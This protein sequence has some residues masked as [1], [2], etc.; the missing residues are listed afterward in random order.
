MVSNKHL[1][2]GLKSSAT[3][4]I[5]LASPQQ[6]LTPPC[7]YPLLQPPLF[8]LVYVDDILVTG[9]CSS[10]IKSLIHSLHQ[11]FSLKDL[12]YLHYF[13]GIEATK[14]ESGGYHLHQSKYILDQ[15]KKANMHDCKTMPTPMIS[16]SKLSSRDRSPYSAP[17]Q[18][19][20]IVGALQYA[21]ITRPEITFS[22]NKVCQF[23][24]NPLDTHWK[25]VKRI[26]RYLSGTVSHGSI[27]NPSSNFNLAAYCDSD[28]GLDLDD[29]RSTSGFCIFFGSNLVTW[30]S[31]KQHV[32]SRSSTEAEYRCLAATVAE[33]TW[34]Q[35][36]L[37]E[38]RIT[39]PRPPTIYCDNMSAVLLTANPFFHSRTKNF[40]LDLHFVRE[41]VLAKQM[42]VHHV[43]ASDQLADGLTKAIS[44]P[45]FAQ[46]KSKLCVLA[47]K[48]TQLGGEG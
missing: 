19:R 2:L 39:I 23:M 31:K 24:Q 1:V 43:P 33:L 3:L 14:T 25:A 22:V 35:P 11:A 5:D 48:P 15:L 28:W 32:V 26:L 41:K 36:L 18:Y 6:S 4:F 17:T 30:S 34:I 47:S 20:S 16:S 29:R 44:T 13:L 8:V 7:S 9:S 40:E 12:G 46:F 27:I 37:S 38:L 45:S 10:A 42:S 21:T